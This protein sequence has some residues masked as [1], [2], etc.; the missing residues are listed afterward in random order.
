MKIMLQRIKQS[1][2]LMLRKFNFPNRISF[3]ET[4]SKNCDA[5]ETK[6]YN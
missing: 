1:H 6:K 2:N 5:E 3:E 4:K